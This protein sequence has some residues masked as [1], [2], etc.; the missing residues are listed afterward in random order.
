MICRYDGYVVKFQANLY[1]LEPNF[2][3]QNSASSYAISICRKSVGENS[4]ESGKAGQ[5]AISD[6]GNRKFH[7]W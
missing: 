5:G 2:G 3:Y 1:T 4:G 7:F 6:N